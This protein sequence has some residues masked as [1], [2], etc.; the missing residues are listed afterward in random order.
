MTQ[1]KLSVMSMEKPTCPECGGH[2]AE[3]IVPGRLRCV[4]EIEDVSWVQSRD[5]F[6]ERLT[7]QPRMREDRVVR[8]RTCGHEYA[9]EVPLSQDICRGTESGKPCGAYSVGVCVNCDSPVCSE[10]VSRI[11]GL[12]ICRRCERG[13]VPAVVPELR[14]HLERERQI[15]LAAQQEAQNRALLAQQEKDAAAEAA[16][17]YEE[18]TPGFPRPP[19]GWISWDDIDKIYPEEK[20]SFYGPTVS[21]MCVVLRRLVPERRRR[22]MVEKRSG[23]FSPARYAVGWGFQVRQSPDEGRSDFLIKRLFADDGRIWTSTGSILKSAVVDEQDLTG[24]FGHWYAGARIDWDFIEE[25]RQ[26][27]IAWRSEQA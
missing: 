15:E 13:S 6:A 27:V 23:L 18:Q 22:F 7:G 25:V 21:E 20:G 26:Q 3:Q 9:V 5:A 10:H 19:A 2:D 4:S 11:G 16:R 17:L 8:K 12:L 14:E 24:S 1:V